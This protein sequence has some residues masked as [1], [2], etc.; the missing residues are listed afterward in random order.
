MNCTSTRLPYRQTGAFSKLAMDYIDQAEALKPFF[1]HPPTV[2][3]LQQAI[4][5]RKQF[6]TNR[7]ILV[8]ELKN[9]TGELRRG[10][11]EN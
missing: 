7:E 2:K 5:A 4:E 9:S 1:A 6:S 10:Q 8:Q 11:S 3:G